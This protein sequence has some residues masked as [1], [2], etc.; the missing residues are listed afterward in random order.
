MY[1]E[2]HLTTFCIHYGLLNR[3]LFQIYNSPPIHPPTSKFFLIIGCFTCT[4]PL[5]VTSRRQWVAA[6]AVTAR[7]PSWADAAASSAQREPTT[8]TT[9]SAAGR[10]QYQ[11]AWLV[12]LFGQSVPFRYSSIKTLLL[13]LSPCWHLNNS[14]TLAMSVIS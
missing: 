10:S 8:A 4:K 7:R 11:R 1:N 3:C 9:W 5:N 12:E 13:N 2:Q 14:L 6:S